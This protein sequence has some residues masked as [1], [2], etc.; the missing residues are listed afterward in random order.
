MKPHYLFIKNE[1]D[2]YEQK[3]TPLGGK[4]SMTHKVRVPRY[5]DPDDPTMWNYWPNGPKEEG[6]LVVAS[7]ADPRFPQDLIFEGTPSDNMEPLDDEAKKEIQRL[8]PGWK[9]PIESLP[10]KVA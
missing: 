4:K 5:L 6:W 7:K 10:T 3:E 9:H 1:E 2:F 8:Q